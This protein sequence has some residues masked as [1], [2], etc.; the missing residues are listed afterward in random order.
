MSDVRT[1]QK[2][3][4]VPDR[5]R[6]V[7][8]PL[9]SG[10]VEAL[11]RAAAGGEPSARLELAHATACALV[12]AGRGEHGAD[13]EELVRLA[14]TVGLDT[15][16]ALWRDAAADSLPGAM[17]ALYLLRTWCQQQGAAVARMYRAGRGLA[18]VD[19][20][21]AGVAD[22]ADPEAIA[23]TADAVLSGAYRGDFAVALERA[24][25]FFRIVAVGRRELAADDEQGAQDQEMAERNRRCADAL[26]RAAAAWRDG[27]LH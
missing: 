9:L 19:E 21:V 24:A 10:D 17:W 7:Q 26:D 4:A 3:E 20:V 27:T 22:N 15:L 25:A 2:G 1:G 8:R 23:A 16:S 12:D 11:A 5:D 13:P 6:R 14:E 18:P